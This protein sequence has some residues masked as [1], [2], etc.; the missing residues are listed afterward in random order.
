MHSSVLCRSFDERRSSMT[1]FSHAHIS[2]G[3]ASCCS[4]F[5]LL[6]YYRG[7][8]QWPRSLK[9][10]SAAA[11]LLGLQAQIPPG[12]WMSLMSA[13]CC[14]VAVSASG[15]SLVQRSPTEC[16]MSECDRVAS[17]MRSPWSARGC[18]ATEENKI[19]D[20]HGVRTTRV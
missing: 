5:Y 10:G 8:S 18:W 17:I 6:H 13:V 2:L 20:D 7:R 3:S 1:K 9:H 4:A 12:T 11:H 19:P 14:Q 16:D 15:W